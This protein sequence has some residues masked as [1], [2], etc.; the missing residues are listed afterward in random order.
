MAELGDHEPD[1]GREAATK[2]AI[3]LALAPAVAVH[4]LTAGRANPGGG[5]DLAPRETGRIDV[6]VLLGTAI[7]ADEYTILWYRFG[8]WKSQRGAAQMA[9][10]SYHRAVALERSALQ[11]L[12]R[13][14]WNDPTYELP[15]RIWRRPVVLVAPKRRKRK[16]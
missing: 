10:I 14:I 12:I 15:A 2:A 9:G 3:A 13:L 7:S 16:G 5:L 6:G 1:A 8:R 11:T 4:T